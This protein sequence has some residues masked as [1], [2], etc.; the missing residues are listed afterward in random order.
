MKPF[1]LYDLFKDF[2]TICLECGCPVVLKETHVDW[3]NK[4]ADL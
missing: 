4:V 2:G 1:T 3:H